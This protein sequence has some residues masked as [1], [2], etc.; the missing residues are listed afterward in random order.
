M[1]NVFSCKNNL[2]ENLISIFL[3]YMKEIY[4]K[5]CFT[6]YYIVYDQFLILVYYKY[7]IRA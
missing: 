6:V 4:E 3:F 5:N 7:N 2:E 1:T